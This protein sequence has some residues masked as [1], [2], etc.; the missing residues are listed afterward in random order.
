M[1]VPTR[2]SPTAPPRA[3]TEA[4]AA[5]AAARGAPAARAARTRTSAPPALRSGHRRTV[6]ISH[7]H[8]SLRRCPSETFIISASRGSFVGFLGLDARSE[9]SFFYA[10]VVRPPFAKPL[11][12]ACAVGDRSLNRWTTKGDRLAGAPTG[13]T[14]VRAPFRAARVP[15]ARLGSR[16]R[17][18][19]A[20][21]GR[22]GVGRVARGA[23]ERAAS[24]WVATGVPLRAGVRR[25]ATPSG[26]GRSTPSC[27][28]RCPRRRRRRSDGAT[29]RPCAWCRAC[30]R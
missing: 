23:G 13:E 4:P 17:G 29:A 3:I 8:R 9:K 15:R 16:V 21:D 12:L 28:P 20:G 2:P 27:T 24:P 19:R 1:H 22:P 7:V 5:A 11:R 6:G 10:R 30:W 14:R 18:G 25:D 26:A